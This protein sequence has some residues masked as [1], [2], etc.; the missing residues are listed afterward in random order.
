VRTKEGVFTFFR[1]D[2]PIGAC[3]YHYGEWSGQEFD[4][5]DK[6]IT[7]TSTCLDVGANIGTHTV[8][9][10]KRCNQ[11]LVFAF[12]PQVYIFQILNANIF[13][14]DCFNVV[15]YQA[16]VSN[17]LT[18]IR[19]P[20]HIPSPNQGN[21]N[22]GEF[23]NT[24]D[25]PLGIQC[26]RLDDTNYFGRTIDFIKMDV[27]GHEPSALVSGTKMITKDKPHMYIEYN[28]HDGNDEVLRV[29]NDLGYNS[30]WHCYPKHNANNYNKSDV[31]IWLN[32]ADLPKNE[33][34][35]DKWYEASLIAIHKDRDTGQYT[36]T[37]QLGDSIVKYLQRKGMIEG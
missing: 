27:E 8:A 25:G 12:E 19:G 1:D 22:Y 20:L 13:M 5:I 9:L 21:F 28:D 6:L 24:G 31:N 14:N 23:K 34:T 29:L 26:I 36:E 4:V 16:G 7:P 2:N 17:T 30:Y 11:G 32:T 15:P 18:E 3:L 33:N 10:A 37:I 35:V